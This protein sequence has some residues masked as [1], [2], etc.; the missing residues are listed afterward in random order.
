MYQL[1]NINCTLYIAQTVGGNSVFNFLN[2]SLNHSS[3]ITALVNAVA[4]TI[5]GNATVQ[6]VLIYQA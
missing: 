3:A 4:A 6:L 1:L 2:L 5:T